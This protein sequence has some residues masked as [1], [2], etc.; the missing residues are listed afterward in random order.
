MGER[1]G[2]GHAYANLGDAHHSLGEFEKAIDYHEQDLKIAKEVGG[3][4]GRGNAYA[5][6][7]NARHSL[8]DFKKAIG[9]HEN[10]LKIAKEVGNRA[11]EGYAYANLGN[12]YHSLGECKKGIDYHERHLKIAK[13]M[14]D[15]VGEG[16]A[17]ANLG[18]AFHSLGDFKK[19]IDCH[20]R[21][22][23]I[24]RQVG[25]LVGEGRAYGNLGNAFHRLSDFKKAIDY[26][27]R[28]L[29]IAKEVGDRAEEARANGNLGNAYHSL[30]D[31]KK[32]IE[33]HEK[34]LKIAEELG[35]R[36]LREYANLGN[37]YF[38]LS[39]FKKA[40][41]YHKRDLRI[42][43]EEGDRSREGRAYANL[44]NAQY[45]LGDFE[46][47]M[48]YY[49]R[50]LKIA[51]EVG[52]RAAEGTAYANLGN[53]CYSRKDFI[54]AIDY[55]ER[56]LNIAKELG[57]K[58]ALAN[59][60]YRLGSSL[61]SIGSLHEAIVH[62]QQSVATFNDIRGHLQFKDEWKISLRNMYETAYAILWRLL[63]KQGK[64]VEALISAEQGRA[65]A[66]KDLME[67]KYGLQTTNAGSAAVKET[68]SDILS[69]FPPNTIF[70]GIEEEEI[71]F[72]VFKKG[73]DVEL[74]R[75]E[76]RDDSSR[77]NVA[78]FLQS[79]M[80]SVRQ[81]IG[82]TADIRCEDRSLESVRDEK[83]ADEEYSRRGLH[84]SMFGSNA[85]R[86]LHDIILDPI[87]DLLHGS[88]VIFVPE[89]PLCLAPYAAFLDLNSKYLCESF[90]IRV[91]PSLTSFKL[92]TDCA[93]D[94][95]IKTGALLVG[96]PWVQG[97]TK[98]KQLPCAREEVEMIGQTLSTS[99]L[100]GRQATK[101][102][103]LKRLS[104][105]ALVH[106]AAHGSME[107]GEI[108]LAPN[109]TNSSQKPIKEDF[110]LTL[111]DVLNVEMRAKLVVLSCCHSARGEIKAEGVVGIARAFLGAG[112]RSVLVALWAIDDEATLE[113]MKSF[114]QQLVRGRSASEALNQ[115]MNSMRESAKFSA[116]KYWAPFV[117]IGDD[118]T[119]EFGG[120]T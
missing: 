48:D 14:G 93:A 40:I 11:A 117:L 25:D 95:H 81:G 27:E 31:F 26:H 12:A 70:M 99:P 51:K 63:L 112:A 110:L 30:G 74:R 58:V 3:K 87:A 114:Y 28:D 89:G 107:T 71:V 62:Y 77:N 111:K 106:I 118:V 35:N 45:R 105:V 60:F 75:K 46:K 102:E 7:G 97:V 2:Q 6:L 13:E 104:S 85:L 66:L 22:L 53:I 8:G 69:C 18:N 83:L 116:V 76:V 56:H 79:L 43:K 98:L 5:N 90:R 10:Q 88:E 78:T 109:P 55:H 57:D 34:H 64:V 39:D 101:N 54:K 21:D 103:V 91:L 41:D 33:H 19:A 24:A 38:R 4:A 82:V 29:K 15:R 84:S 47:A 1:A 80:Q 20:D 115:A 59:S 96:D 9:Y 49:E 50:H 68:D 73:K 52:D 65:Q 17:F 86:V 119:L 42:A 36:A 108:A 67:L 100:I 23:K 44:G 94:Y 72:W 120:S 37:A 113:F 61:E 32:A 92:I 16:R